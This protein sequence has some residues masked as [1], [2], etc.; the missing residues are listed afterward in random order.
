MNIII[1]TESLTVPV[2]TG[3]QQ[4]SSSI[5][6]VHA[7]P[8]VRKLARQ[9]GL[10]LDEISQLFQRPNISKEDLYA[11][12]NSR[13]QTTSTNTASSSTDNAGT[14]SIPQIQQP[15]W[16]LFGDVET[17]PLSRINKISAQH[18]HRA[19]LNVP[20]VTLFDETDI[21]NLESYRNQV[22]HEANQLGFSL[23]SLVFVMKAVVSG[24]KLY[25]RFN[26]AIDAG[27]ENL[28][29]RNYYNLGIAVETSNGL[30]VPVIKA[31]DQKSI[32]ELAEELADVSRRARE[33]K[34]KA[35]EMQGGCFSISN[36]GSIGGT[37]F[38]PIVNAPE[39]GILGLGR[40]SWRSSRVDDA[41]VDRLMQPLAVSYDH[42][43]VDGTCAARFVR[44]IADGLTDA[45]RLLL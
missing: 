4:E 13:M 33:G 37:N 24:L 1:Q 34:L 22:K 3:G 43:V 15:D 5:G 14:L 40:A 31:V 2:D 32:F 20:Q 44:H 41:L 11:F 39:V 6:S 18:L 27:G 12:V 8:S 26:S 38:T 17:L 10:D 30:V 45:H 7:S 19:W 23:T 29:Q 36:L 35:S 42:R 21:T 25:P 28:V 9:L 16:V